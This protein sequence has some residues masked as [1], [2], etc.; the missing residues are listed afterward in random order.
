M[1][2]IAPNEDMLRSLAK[3]YK[4]N[5][6][7]I[8]EK[9]IVPN[10]KV[11]KSDAYKLWETETQ[12]LLTTWKDECIGQLEKSNADKKTMQTDVIVTVARLLERQLGSDK[13][14]MKPPLPPF[15]MPR[16]L[17]WV[18]A[19]ST[20]CTD[21]S[22]F[23][24]MFHSERL[25]AKAMHNVLSVQLYLVNGISWTRDNMRQDIH[26][27]HHQGP[28]SIERFIPLLN[29]MSEEA[30]TIVEWESQIY[31]ERPPYTFTVDSTDNLHTALKHC[32]DKYSGKI[33]DARDKFLSRS[34]TVST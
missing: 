32:Y 33:H 15:Q 1:K 18:R 8:P 21:S 3:A 6:G 4:E 16:E 30:I 22:K 31:C 7:K 9:C 12:G 27:A 25:P 2:I 29:D 34:K 17:R 23:V 13:E 19:C 14:S 5:K 11:D 26:D 10:M 24:A 20:S 28:S